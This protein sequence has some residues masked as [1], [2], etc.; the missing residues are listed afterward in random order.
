MSEIIIPKG[1]ELFPL[2]NTFNDVMYPMVFRVV[3]EGTVWGFQVDKKH[4]NMMGMCHGGALM[5][6]MD[7]AL[8]AAVCHKM[9]KFTG[10]P[11][12][13]M[14]FD[15]LSKAVIGDWIFAEVEAL[16]I[17]NTMGFAQGIIKRENGDYLVRA[18]GSFKL[19]K[20]IEGSSGVSVQDL[21]AKQKNADNG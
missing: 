2:D 14:S 6:L 7:F 1:F 11:T 21:L 10:T 15:F 12:I 17:T 5:T 19:P 3:E 13:S 9:G 16:K 20:D 8:S 4:S 18:S